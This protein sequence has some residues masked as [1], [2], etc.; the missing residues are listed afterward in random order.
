MADE[1]LDLLLQTLLQIYKRDDD[2]TIRRVKLLIICI[3]DKAVILMHFVQHFPEKEV[4]REV[5]NTAKEIIEY[6]F[7]PQNLSADCG[8]V[9]LY[10]QLRELEEELDSTVEDVVDYIRQQ[11][12]SP[13]VG[14]SSVSTLESEVVDPV[15]ATELIVVNSKRFRRLAE[16]I[17]SS[18]RELADVD[19]SDTPP[20]TIK[21]VA[22]GFS[23]DLS[24]STAATSS[25]RPASSKDDVVVVGFDEDILQMMDRITDY[26]SYSN[27]QILSIVGMGG[28]GK[29]TLARHIFDRTLIKQHFDIQAWVTISQDYSV[30]SIL[31]Q[32]LASLK[33]KVDPVGRD[34]SKGSQAEEEEIYKI[35]WGRRYLIVM[36][37]IWSAEA[38]DR[39]R[40]LFPDNRNG[41]RIILTTRQMDV[42]TAVSHNIHKMDFLDDQQSWRLFQ[43]KDFY[44]GFLER[45]R[46][47]RKLK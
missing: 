34:S 29:S 47:G 22:V 35:L 1:A 38:W 6:L 2:L 33:R 8:S 7:S 4:I 39:V 28:I 44:R 32:L 19:P 31:S 40:M 45:Q 9:R 15:V 37:D 16:K 27:L 17:E 11:S 21:D 23:E 24:D 43:Q 30:E 36:D 25:S 26:S 12:D 41:S 5:A 10:D 3:H 20:L 42:A 46:C 14:S 18:D 13:A